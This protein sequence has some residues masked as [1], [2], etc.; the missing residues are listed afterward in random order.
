MLKTS[1]LKR[2]NVH[3]KELLPIMFL[4]ILIFFLSSHITYDVIVIYVKAQ[5]YPR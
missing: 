1:L 4:E 5:L 3:L 2:L